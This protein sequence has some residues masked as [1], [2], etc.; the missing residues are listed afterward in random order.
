MTRRA[1]AFGGVGGGVIGWPGEVEEQGWIRAQVAGHG[2]LAP[3]SNCQAPHSWCGAQRLLHLTTK[4]VEGF[5]HWGSKK[6][7]DEYPVF[8]DA[9]GS[10]L[11]VPEFNFNLSVSPVGLI[12][13]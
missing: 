2:E 8:P 10:D 11:D 13:R 4:I 1:R 6:G 7:A 9:R 3:R 12:G 5:G